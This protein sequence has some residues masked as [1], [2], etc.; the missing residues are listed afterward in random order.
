VILS[1]DDEVCDVVLLDVNSSLM[2]IKAD[3]RNISVVILRNRAIR[4]TKSRIYETTV[5][6]CERYRAKD[7]HYLNAFN[8]TGI[9]LGRRGTVKI[10]VTFETDADGFYFA[11]SVHSTITIDQDGVHF[12]EE[13]RTEAIKGADDRCS[14]ATFVRNPL[15][16]CL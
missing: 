3:H 7:N 13:K 16:E 8:L 11:A 10:N 6:E 5:H 14:K 1:G 2:E 12:P 4:M 9:A 15:D